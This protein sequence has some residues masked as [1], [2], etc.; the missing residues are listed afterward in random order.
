[1]DGLLD[2]DP[3][4]DNKLSCR[5]TFIELKQYSEKCNRILEIYTGPTY[6]LLRLVMEATLLM[7]RDQSRPAWE[8]SSKWKHSPCAGNSDAA[9]RPISAIQARLDWSFKD[10]SPASSR[11]DDTDE[12]TFET[13]SG[14]KDRGKDEEA[15]QTGCWVAEKDSSHHLG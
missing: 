12:M 3:K 7:D 10:T 5:N 4:E 13:V 9:R 15:T 6:W 8:W 1:M 14:F 11:L 2:R